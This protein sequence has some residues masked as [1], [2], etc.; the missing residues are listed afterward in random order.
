M[1]SVFFVQQFFLSSLYRRMSCFLNYLACVASISVRF[2]ARSRHFSLFG[3][4][5]IRA[6][7][8]K[9][10][11]R[12]GGGE[13]REVPSLASPPPSRTFLRSP[14]FLRGQKAKHASNVRKALRKRLLRRL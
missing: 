12:G 7:A 11:R 5:K 14:Q 2:S 1:F 4:A 9:N 13:A 3:R 6:S 10:R 8:K